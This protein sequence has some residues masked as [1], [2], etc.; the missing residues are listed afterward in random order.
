MKIT[1]LFLVVLLQFPAPCA[2]AAFYQWIDSQGVTHFTDNSDKIP[3]RYRKKARRIA[4]PDQ[5]APAPV[6]APAPQTAAPAPQ[7]E[8]QAP[9]YG[10]QT[11]QWW[12]GKFSTLRG[13]LKAL[14]D[15]LPGKE[16]RL[17]ELRRK[18]VI[19]SK[20]RDRVA[21]NSMQAEISADEARVTD[22]QNQLGA[23]ELDAAKALV[24]AEWRQ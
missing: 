11:E 14:Q 21:V 24:P 6:S 1:M 13:E 7:T 18:R 2:Q 19:Y 12:R 22:L 23:L 9:G 3:G 10:G 4:L 17:A 8:A 20:A 16:A 5:A 15:G